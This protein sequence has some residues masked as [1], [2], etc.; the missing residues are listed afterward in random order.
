MSDCNRQSRC[1]LR[2]GYAERLRPSGIRRRSKEAAPRS[3]RPFAAPIGPIGRRLRFAEG[4]LLGTEDQVAIAT[5]LDLLGRDQ[6]A[7]AFTAAPFAGGVAVA[8][9]RNPTV[10]SLEIGNDD[11][12]SGEDEQ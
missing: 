12:K 4:N 2:R 6:E 3:V 10:M 11:H 5:H 7:V 9:A 8:S 1:F